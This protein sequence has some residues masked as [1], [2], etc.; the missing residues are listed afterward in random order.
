MSLTA[1]LSPWQVLAVA[2][3]SEEDAALFYTELQKRVK[4]PILIDKLK[5]LAGEE[6]KHKAI[7]ER[8]FRQ[9]Y[10][11]RPKDIPPGVDRLRIK[12]SL[13][14]SD[15]VPALFRAALQAEV[16]AERYYA[17]AA[18]GTGAADARQVLNYLSRVERSHQAMI[19]A[20]LDLIEKFP[21]YY[22]VEDFHIAQ[23]LFH[24]GP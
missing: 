24:V 11:D 8:L 16:E 22:K 10:P 20:E 5:F 6:G 3:R 15:D 1:N 4:N 17:E 14:G 7:L 18:A 9:K 13:D 12:A 23:D 21:D 19:T 2:V